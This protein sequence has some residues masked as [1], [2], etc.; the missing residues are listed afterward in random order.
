MSRYTWLLFFHS[1]LLLQLY[2]PPVSAQNSARRPVFYIGSY[3]AISG[4]ELA[5]AHPG[6]QALFMKQL[7]ITT[8]NGNDFNA[9]LKITDNTGSTTTYE[10]QATAG[11]A[12]GQLLVQLSGRSQSD[13]CH[14]LGGGEG[15][16]CGQYLGTACTGQFPYTT[17]QNLDGTYILEISRWCG[18]MGD[19]YLECSGECTGEVAP[20]VSS[21]T[22][23]TYAIEGGEVNVTQSTVIIQG[24]EET[25]TNFFGDSIT[26]LQSEFTFEQSDTVEN[27]Y[28][29]VNYSTVNIEAPDT[30]V[31][32]IITGAPNTC[33]NWAYW[34]MQTSGNV[35]LTENWD[36]VFFTGESLLEQG[37]EEAWELD[38]DSVLKYLG[39]SDDFSYQFTICLVTGRLFGSNGLGQR[40]QFALVNRTGADNLVTAETA[41]IFN[42][43]DP[44]YLGGACAVIATQQVKENNEFSIVARVLSSLGSP[45]TILAHDISFT[46][47][48]LPGGCK[49]TTNILNITA[50][51][52][53][54]QL[55]NGT[56]TTVRTIDEHRIAI[57]NDGVCSVTIENAPISYWKEVCVVCVVC[58]V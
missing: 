19:V 39:D 25:T 28:I 41:T 30:S 17:Y 35:S 29:T 24:G 20:C 16:L 36:D 56:C 48:V 5:G 33:G 15:P 37:D 4:A 46:L 2:S 45:T 3:S 53:G 12:S 27:T 31:Y 21:L 14:A 55:V 13:Q 9:T 18:V 51:F 6:S 7:S 42:Q 47:A 8:L 26:I 34:R 58:D 57:D 49:G 50:L 44:E 52:N 1:V 43:T 54:T 10:L 38:T 23:N 11:C 32:N 40:L 22:Q